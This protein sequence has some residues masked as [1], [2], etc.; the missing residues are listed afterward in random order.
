MDMHLEVESSENKFSRLKFLIFIFK[1][2][3]LTI[4]HLS[5]KRQFTMLRKIQTQ[6]KKERFKREED[7]SE[8]LFLLSASD[9]NRQYVFFQLM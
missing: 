5:N 8:K 6:K 2:H 3:H 1:S 7:D 9:P 4:V